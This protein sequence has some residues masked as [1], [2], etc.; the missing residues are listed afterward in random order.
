[1]NIKFFKNI[2]VTK[3]IV[4]YTL[5]FWIFL[6]ISFIVI[7]TLYPRAGTIIFAY[8]NLDKVTFAWEKVPFDDEHFFV[9]E[10][11]DKE[12]IVNSNTLYQFY[13]YIK[14]Y[15]L[16]VPYIETILKEYEIPDDFKYL[17]I[18]ESA[19][20]NDVVSH[21]GAA[22]IWQFI[23]ETAIRYGLRVDE[24]VDERYNFEKST[25]AA[26]EYFQDLH[27][28]FSNWTLV[29]AAYNRGENWLLRDMKSQKVDSYYDLYLNDETS[30]YVFRILAIKYLLESYNAKKSFLDMVMWEPYTEP[31]TKKISVSKVDNLIEW[32][33]SNWQSY[34]TVRV[35]NP[36]ILQ[37]SLPEWSW[38]IR[39]LD[40]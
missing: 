4:F 10:R 19:L 17:A 38:E 33:T 37:D 21:A 13:L 1:M 18:A 27:K 6:V 2:F 36:W 12:F 25:V 5:G 39:V 35:L 9:K 16:Y 29:A 8:P 30:R 22:G 24:Y 26:A 32:A 15:D 11:F 7:L 20:R 31:R 14:R 3:K 40:L 34:N 28:K 23:P